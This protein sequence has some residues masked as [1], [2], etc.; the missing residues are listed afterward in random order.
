[1]ND[2]HYR[3][4]EIAQAER[5][6]GVTFGAVVRLISTPIRFRPQVISKSS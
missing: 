6:D 4:T 5:S 2:D 1:M 3:K